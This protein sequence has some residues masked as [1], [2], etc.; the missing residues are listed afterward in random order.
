V[1]KI[2]NFVLPAPVP[3]AVNGLPPAT[4]E[5]TGRADELANLLD[6]LRSTANVTVI[7]GV[8]GVGKTALALHAAHQASSDFPG[9]TLF[10]DL[11]G[12]DDTPIEP[13][14]ALAMFLQ[15]LGVRGEHVPEDPDA[16]AA[17]YR[18]V[19]QK[20]GRML[21]MLDNARSSNQVMPL[22]T[23]PSHHLLITSRHTLAD[24]PGARQLELGVMPIQDAVALIDTTLRMRNRDDPRVADDPQ[25]AAELATLCDDLPLALNIVAAMLAAEPK[26]LIAELAAALR[27]TPSRFKD[28]RYG[29][30]PGLDAAFDLSYARLTQ[31][32]QRMFEF[33]ALI[34]PPVFS[35]ET[36]AALAALPER[37]TQRLL[38]SL[39][40]AHMIEAAEPSGR[41]R[42]HDL[43]REYAITLIQTKPKE[44]LQDTYNRLCAYFL[45]SSA[46]ACRHVAEQL[47][48]DMG[49]RF[50]DWHAADVWLEQSWLSRF[51]D[52]EKA[53]DWIQSER[54]SLV[55]IANLS[56][57]LDALE[58][59]QPLARL[60]FPYCMT[61]GDWELALDLGRIAVR[62]AGHA[63]DWQ[64][65]LAI[66]V[67]LK[68]IVAFRIAEGGVRDILLPESVLTEENWPRDV[69]DIT[70]DIRRVRELPNRLSYDELAMLVELACAHYKNQDYAAMRRWAL[71]AADLS[72]ELDLRL[73]LAHSNALAG[74]AASAMGRHAAVREYLS[75]ARDGY[76]EFRVD[77]LAEAVGGRLAD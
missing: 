52:R 47:G 33:M 6:T 11:R 28:L 9:G 44:I 56:E 39:L 1:G 16:C 63:G 31:D 30:T 59:T 32:E 25:G 57:V 53:V 35:V 20:R 36:A 2:E 3:L 22:L 54:H 73:F 43:L 69:G 10:V 21:I 75:K 55:F 41:Y 24:I 66:L 50:P 27:E 38:T 8:A 61:W 46:S 68:N 74:V 17:L 37:D 58:V 60:L 62:R 4:P 34:P 15:S 42:I 13:T 18:S 5:F 49:A 76:R 71:K 12:Y 45:V 14:K 70:E 51:P 77:D 65:E 7:S 19:I 64:E 26:K 23:G 29:D 72:R 40:R 48:D 67:W